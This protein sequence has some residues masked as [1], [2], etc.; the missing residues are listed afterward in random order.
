MRLSPGQDVAKALMSLKAGETVF[1]DRGAYGPTV[2][3]NLKGVRIQGDGAVFAGG[4]VS[5]KLQ[6]CQNVDLVGLCFQGAAQY[7]VMVQGCQYVTLTEC[8]ADRCGTTGMLTANSSHVTFDTCRSDNAATQHGFYCS[9]SGD[10]L[11]FINCSATNNN[12]A[13]IQVNADERPARADRAHDSISERVS[14]QGCT[15]IGNQKAGGAS[16]NIACCRQVRIVRNT[17]EQNFGRN[18]IA[19]FEDGMGARFATQDVEIT[20]NQGEFASGKGVPVNVHPTCKNVRQ[21]GNGWDV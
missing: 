18:H 15:L 8:R 12:R 20:G 13:G 1:L 2:L 3:R 7:G 11:S 19:L 17:I 10:D 6:D 14:I 21:S 9:Q 4:Q 5:L 16:I